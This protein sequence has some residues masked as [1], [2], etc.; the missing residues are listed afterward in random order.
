MSVAA[1]FDA[2]RALKRETTGG[3]LTQ[4][5]V[6]A[7]N[8]IIG[9]WKPVAHGFALQDAAAFFASLKASFGALSQAQVDGYNRLL[10]AMANWPI[11]YVAYGLATARHETADNLAP[12]VEAYRKDDAWRRANLSYYPWHGRGDV[13]LT[14]KFNYERADE[15]L[16]LGGRLV[17]NPELALDPVISAKIIVRG[18]EAGWFTGKRLSQY[19]PTTGEA[20]AAQ[21]AQARRIVNGTDKAQQIAGVAVK[22]QA[23]LKAGGWE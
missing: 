1:F 10:N 11:A 18:M 17:A 4:E 23:A 15:E 6:D 14:H 8:A 12:V 5:E 2:A 19:L 13:Q 3:G 7:F 21:F 20:N 22:I 16:G 9:K